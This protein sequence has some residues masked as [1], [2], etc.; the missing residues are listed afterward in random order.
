M[1][2]I[3]DDNQNVLLTVGRKINKFDIRWGR[4]LR[5]TWAAREVGIGALFI[6]FLRSNGCDVE[7][8]NTTVGGREGLNRGGAQHP[9]APSL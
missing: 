1:R 3:V 2:D 9:F 7:E 8:L 4:V 5:L 6:L